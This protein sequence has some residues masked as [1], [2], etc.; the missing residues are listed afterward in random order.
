MVQLFEGQ[1]VCTPNALVVSYGEKQLSYQELNIKVNQLAH[2][3]TDSYFINA[4]DVIGLLLPKSDTALIAVLAI[5]K[6]G[7][8]FLPIDVS[9]PEERAS[10][11]SRDSNMKLLLS[12]RTNINRIDFEHRLCIDELEFSLASKENLTRSISSSDLCYVIYTSG[13][14]GKPKGVMIEHKSSVNMSLSQIKLFEV[15]SKDRIVW[16]A[17]FSFDASVSE[18]MMAMYSG[19]ALIIPEDGIIKDKDK[20]SAFLRAT[21][22]TVIT[23]PPSYLNVLTNEDIRGLRCIITAGESAYVR[24]ATEVSKTWNSFRAMYDKINSFK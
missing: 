3:L 19:A 16:F 9:C 22:S 4:D 1:V 21:N 20:L 5:L 14:T 18:L 10:Y 2:Y 23:L 11:F 8:A 15:S 24:S 12:D 7:A 6:C 17:S 13:S